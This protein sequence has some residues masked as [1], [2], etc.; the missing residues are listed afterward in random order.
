MEAL[1]DR[2]PPKHNAKQ[3]A[4]W[5]TALFRDP[6]NFLAVKALTILFL[7]FIC[8]SIYII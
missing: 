7:M 2:A 3:S 4:I 8:K 1:T 6:N 5:A